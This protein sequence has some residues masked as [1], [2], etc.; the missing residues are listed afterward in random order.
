MA[1]NYIP[2]IVYNATTYTFPYPPE[3]DLGESSEAVVKDSVSLAGVQQTSVQYIEGVLKLTFKFLL[4]ADITALN[5][6]FQTW[7]VYGK[8]FDYYQHASVG[9]YV[10]YQLKDKK[11]N[12]SVIIR[13]GD[14][15]KVYKVDMSFRRVIL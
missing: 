5:T 8:S 15:T 14:G 6:F 12:P 3:T 7:G 13:R 1:N 10:T 11:L 4:D 2:K 9:S